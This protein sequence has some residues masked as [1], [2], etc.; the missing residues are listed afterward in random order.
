MPA[1]SNS[2]GR[3]D[4]VA[5][6][7][8]GGYF[9]PRSERVHAPEAL[10]RAVPADVLKRRLTNIR[11][12]PPAFRGGMERRQQALE[13]TEMVSNVHQVHFLDTQLPEGGSEKARFAREYVANLVG[14]ESA[15]EVV[16]FM[17]P[18]NLDPSCRIT[19]SVPGGWPRPCGGPRRPDCSRCS[20]NRRRPTWRA[21][22]EWCPARSRSGTSA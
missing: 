21:T 14:A 17:Q 3:A 9:R 1:A 18:S 20:W 16:F 8:V 2:H 13:G 4:M 12:K 7:V 22:P 5:D 11:E 6:G 10:D 15:G 19:I